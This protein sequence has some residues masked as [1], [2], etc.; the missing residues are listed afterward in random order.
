[1]SFGKIEEYVQGSSWDDYESKVLFYFLANEIKL[2]LRKKHVFLAVCGSS[3]FSIARKEVLPK[4]L[5]EVSFKEIIEALRKKFVIRP[6]EIV[7]SY[8]FHNRKQQNGEPFTDFLDDLKKIGMDCNFL[9]T[10]R[11]LRD[12]IVCGIVDSKV[13]QQLLAIQNLDYAKAVDI[14]RINELTLKNVQQ[15]RAASSIREETV[16]FVEKKKQEYDTSNRCCYR[17]GE[18]GHLAKYCNRKLENV[19]CKFCH[20]QGH[21]LKACLLKKKGNGRSDVHMVDQDL[22]SGEEEIVNNLHHANDLGPKLD[23]IMIQVVLDGRQH[24]MEVDSGASMSIIGKAEFLKLWPKNTALKPSNVILR[25]W[26]QEKIRVL[27]SIE[28]KVQC[29]ARSATLPLLV[30]P[31]NSPSLMGRNWFSALGISVTGMHKV[32][33]RE[34]WLLKEEFQEIF[35]DGLGTYTGPEVSIELDEMVQPIFMKSRKVPFPLKVKVEEEIERQIQLGVLEPV[36]YSKWASPVVPVLK[37]DGTVRLCGD[38]K[39]TLNKAIVTDTYPLPTANESFVALSGA[40]VFTKLDLEQ[41]YTQMKVDERSADLLTINTQKGLFRVKRMA[42]GIKSAPGLFQRTME[43]LLAGIPGVAVLLDDILISGKDDEE[44]D[45]RVKAVLGR[46][47]SAGLRLKKAKCV[48][49][50]NEVVFL[51][52]KVDKHG[53][54]PTEEKIAAIKN[55]PTPTNK[56]ELQAFLGLLGFYERFLRGKSTI[57]EPLHRLLDKKAIWIWS[58]KHDDAFARVKDLLQ[59]DDLLVHYDL[60]KP[61][62]LSCD[63]SPYGVGA[64]LSHVMEDG[65]ERPIAYGSRTLH[66][67]ERNYAQIDKEA[68]SIMFGLSKFHQYVFGRKFRIVTDHKPLLGLLHPNKRI[69]EVISPRMFRWSLKLGT[70]DYDLEFR[71]GKL[72]SNADGLSRLPLKV[73]E[74][75]DLPSEELTEI[76][77]LQASLDAPISVGRIAQETSMDAELK[78]VYQYTLHGWPG[79]IPSEVQPFAKKQSEFTIEQNCLLWGTRVIVP[80]VLREEILSIIHSIHQGICQMKAV[81]R[82]YVWWP[83]IDDD[84]ERLVGKCVQCQ[85]NRNNPPKAPSHPW[86]Y[87]EKPWSRLHLDFAGPFQ[88][89]IL[90]IVVDAYSKWPEVKVVPSTSSAAVIKALRDMFSTHG[91]PDTIMT[92]NGTAFTSWDFKE[93]LRRNGVKHVLSSPYHPSSNGQVERMVGTV[94]QHLRKMGDEG[95]DL[96]IPRLLLQLRSTPCTTTGK[97]P[98]SLLMNRELETVLGRMVPRPATNSNSVKIQ[99]EGRVLNVGDEVMFRTYQGNPKWKPGKIIGK[100]GGRIY[101][102][103]DADDRRVI[104]HIDQLLRRNP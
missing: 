52:Y 21:L 22:Q 34:D 38:Y 41:A 89:K 29:G 63:A 24:D 69:P 61:L 84:I 54:H 81:A 66:Q 90:F 97:T 67:H 47:T 65:S 16:Q 76:F 37:P 53:I 23:A 64:V 100:K 51:G 20:K 2:E 58:Q 74:S 45:E 96:K 40:S 80:K 73:Q 33:G 31:G 43:A 88:G 30:A 25:T 27:G 12:Q 94:K 4:T 48:F 17:C 55:A 13:Q 59:S 87:P 92:D 82:S 10:D 99:E 62:V 26:T 28:T 14:C 1:M 68:L 49:G 70:Y 72:H 57:L 15:I 93:F 86:V 104:R 44:H 7:C 60:N 42:F 8:R 18:L 11:M 91:L 83:H 9:E 39:G 36:S 6:S 98:S 95:W 46:L 3:L 102:L 79:I 75:G 5:D 71:P 101:E 85:Q 78:L 56:T 103:E 32:G 35:K 19:I 77:L 50:A